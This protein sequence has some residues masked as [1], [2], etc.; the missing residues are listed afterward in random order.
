MSDILFAFQTKN[1][2]T[3]RTI[4]TCPALR[5]ARLVWEEEAALS[6]LGRAGKVE[7]AHA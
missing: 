1:L 4:R 5:K 2:Y 6:L 3:F 7:Q